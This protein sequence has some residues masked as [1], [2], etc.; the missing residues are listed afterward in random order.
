MSFQ[1]P[2]RNGST[3][4]A[5][6]R[7]N[8]LGAIPGTTLVVGIQGTRWRLPGHGFSHSESHSGPSF[9]DKNTQGMDTAVD[10]ASEA[11]LEGS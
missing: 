7:Q 6:P 8:L 10:G 1:R 3:T 9:E 4:T 11:S 5:L 2:L